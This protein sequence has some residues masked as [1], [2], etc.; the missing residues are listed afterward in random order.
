V[1]WNDAKEF[2]RWLSRKTG[3]PYRLLT[4]AEWEY[5]ARAGSTSAYSWGNNIGTGN[6]N[7]DGCG[8]QWDKRQTAPVGSF[9]TNAFGLYDMPANVWEWCEDKWPADYTGGPPKD[10]SAWLGGDGSL[11]VIRGG[12]W[13][14]DPRSLRSAYR[15]RNQAS[16]RSNV[17]GFRV[18]RTL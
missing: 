12:S 9:H 18:A 14:H 3:Q 16:N 8:S 6:A 10:G 17:V 2:V 1:S 7:C 15:Y 4:E 13:N 5:A 11:R